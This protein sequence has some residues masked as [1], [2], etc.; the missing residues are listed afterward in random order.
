MA[1][2]GG[3][4]HWTGP[5]LG[6]ILLG[7]T[8]QLLTVTISSEINVLV[9]GIMLVLFVVAAPE[10]TARPAR[11]FRWRGFARGGAA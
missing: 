3:T 2:I 5:V 11:R 9:L 6:A 10:G 8:Q 4:A 1:L 7:V